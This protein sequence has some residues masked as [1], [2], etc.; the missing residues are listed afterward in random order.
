MVRRRARVIKTAGGSLHVREDGTLSINH[1]DPAVRKVP[2]RQ[3]PTPPLEAPSLEREREDVGL[4]VAGAAGKGARFKLSLDQKDQG[5]GTAVA[6]VYVPPAPPGSKA[7]G[8]RGQADSSPISSAPGLNPPA[9]RAPPAPP[10]AVE[11]GSDN[12]V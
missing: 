10:A 12:A 6:S 3:S 8:T 11:L 9:A 4:D 1:R 7:P 2:V 5:Q